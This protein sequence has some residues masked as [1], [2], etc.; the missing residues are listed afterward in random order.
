MPRANRASLL[1]GDFITAF[2][3]FTMPRAA[4]RIAD[5]A[6]DKCRSGESW[7]QKCYGIQYVNAIFIVPFIS[8]EC[9]TV[10]A[11]RS[12]HGFAGEQRRAQRAICAK[13]LPAR[14]GARCA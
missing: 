2:L 7:S 14:Y 5:R 1:V 9:P 13:L 12:A 8:T 6:P 11:N 10:G 4:K 3:I